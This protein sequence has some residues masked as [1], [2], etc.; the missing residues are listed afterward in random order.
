[1]DY[2]KA[3]A[4]LEKFVGTVEASGGILVNSKGHHLPAGDPEWLDLGDAYMDACAVLDRIPVT[5][6]DPEDPA[7]SSETGGP[8]FRCT[9]CGDLEQLPNLRTHAMEH[10]PSFAGAPWNIVQSLFEDVEENSRS[11]FGGVEEK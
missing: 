3:L 10:Q 11:L 8:M 1:M 2:S 6:Q 5:T 9:L 7:S 4:A